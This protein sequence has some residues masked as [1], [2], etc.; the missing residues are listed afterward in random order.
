[1]KPCLVVDYSRTGMTSTMASKIAEACGGELDVIADVKSR[2]GLPGY[3]RS[4]YESLTRK[5]PPVSMPTKAPDDYDVLI[6]GT[7][8]WAGH[9][10]APMR[11]YITE[12]SKHFNNVAAFCTMGGA[13]GDKVL[14]EISALCGKPLVGRLVLTDDEIEHDRYQEKVARFAEGITS[15]QQIQPH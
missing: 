10:S 7:P 1:M 5:T 3:V 14:D 13:G 8:V 4:A 15:S 11:T 6:L 9:I 12:N 2:R